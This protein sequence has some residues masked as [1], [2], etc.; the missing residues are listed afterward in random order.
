MLIFTNKNTKTMFRLF[1]KNAKVV[2]CDLVLS[3]NLNSVALYD[4]CSDSGRRSQPN[5]SLNGLNWLPR[6]RNFFR[7]FL[8]SIFIPERN[9]MELQWNMDKLVNLSPKL[10]EI[11]KF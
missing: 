10:H 8:I 3:G 6:R 2:T 1:F 9:F 5:T 4:S 7:C 11:N